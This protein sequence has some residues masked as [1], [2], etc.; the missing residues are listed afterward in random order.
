MRRA[1]RWAVRSLAVVVLLVGVP[2]AAWLAVL[3]TLDAVLAPLDSYRPA[4]M[5]EVEDSRGR[6]IDRYAEER[7][8]WVP[9]EE[10]PPAL[11]QAVLAAE[12]RRYWDHPGVDPLGIL[13]AALVNQRAGEIRQGGSTITQQ[14]VKLL[15]VGRERS[16]RR[17][18]WEAALALR[19][20]QRQSKAWVLELYL[21]QVYLGAGNHGVETA[22]RDYFGRSARELDV[23]EAAVLAGLIREPGRSDPHQAPQRA[24][25]VR[26]RVLQALVAE[27][28]LT[29]A[30]A[31]RHVGRPVRPLDGPVQVREA[32]PLDAWRTLV[33]RELQERF[34]GEWPA[35]V[36]LRVRTTL[37][38]AVQDAAAAAV[39]AAAEAVEQRQGMAP[40]LD[41]LDEGGIARFLEG[42]RG[43]VLAAG[44]CAR[45]VATGRRGELDTGGGRVRLAQGERA[46]WVRA[47]GGEGP[48]R[49]VARWM[50]RGTVWRICREAG[51]GVVLR[52]PHWVEGAAVVLDNHSGSVLAAV[53]G[54]A[55]PLEGFH[56]ATQAARQ[57]GSSFKPV[58]YA[59][60]FEQGMVFWDRVLDGP[61]AVR[62]SQRTWRPQNYSRSYRGPTRLDAAFASSLNT[63]AVRLVQS[64]G[65]EAVAALA[66]RL[67]YRSEMRADLSIAL[68]TSEVTV[69]EQANMVRTMV[70]G[71]RHR[72][73]VL[74]QE[75]VTADGQVFQAG[76]TVEHALLP[77]AVSLPGHG[78]QPVVA[79]A[80]ARQ[81]VDLMRGVVERGT[82]TAARAEGMPRIGKTG[83]T[84]SY[85]DAWF[86]GATPRHSV[87]VWIG[88][89]DHSPLGDGETG[90]VAALPAW[91]EIVDSLDADGGRFP[92]PDD[93]M[94][95]R[96]GGGWS[97]APRAA[98]STARLGHRRRGALPSFPG[99]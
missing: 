17:K 80:V 13:R 33:R 55:M 89:D 23:A 14:L 67:G 25:V 86:I 51:A 85:A 65:A 64:T 32:Q 59:A 90:S 36:G 63:V 6:R 57:P 52:Q 88:V 87:A 95:L 99:G 7:R 62:G 75:L 50:A 92:I 34:G 76:D 49:T 40:P 10:L 54:R 45:A 69:L 56:R 68:G 84:T 37:D 82:G 27:G 70:N 61:L 98:R 96:N 12:D 24:G 44:E 60:A 46:R 15:V 97:T 47:P 94:L 31:L 2:G 74:L 73:P 83:T 8:V 81:V 71:G 3:P 5:V 53:G 78:G 1:V 19:L 77:A 26:D 11:I 38:P 20:E 9:L 29:K 21:N 72:E 43:V 39:A 79:G 16:L 58:V 28:Q 91:V 41:E 42:H 22:A 30:E 93:S 35:A 48:R 18:L 4:T 66:R